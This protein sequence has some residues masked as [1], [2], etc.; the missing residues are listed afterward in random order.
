MNRKL[1][2]GMVGG[3]RGALIGPVHRLAAIMDGKAE[4]VAGAF[5][6]DP[7]RSRASGADLL[8]VGE[9]QLI[10]SEEF[11]GQCGI[12]CHSLRKK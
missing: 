10:G 5:A 2:F 7:A 1:R 3:G 11:C 8:L 6:S 9:V 4:L 12:F